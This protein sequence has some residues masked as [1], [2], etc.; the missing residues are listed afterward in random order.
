MQKAIR[1]FNDEIDR[2]K[3]I[4]S[5]YRVTSISEYRKLSGETIPHVFILIDNFDAVK[6][7][8]FQEVFENMMIK[9]TRE[10]LALDMQVTLTASRAN[11]MKTPMYINMKTR[12]AMFYMINQRCRT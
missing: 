11:A 6:D 10:G 8:P 7:S 2:R 3:K 12:I 4:L 1:I 9:M 5:Q